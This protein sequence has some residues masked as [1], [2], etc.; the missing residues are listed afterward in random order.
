MI[1]RILKSFKVNGFW[2]TVGRVP[3]TFSRPICSALIGHRLS[4]RNRRSTMSL[5]GDADAVVSLTSYGSRIH[6]VHLTIESIARGSTRPRR[7]IL[8]LDDKEALLDPTSELRRLTRRGLELRYAPDYGPHKKYFPALEVSLEDGASRLI[9]ADDDVIYPRW[10]LDRLMSAAKEDPSSIVAYR[11][12]R[13]TLTHDGFAAWNEWPLCASSTPSLLNF[14]IGEAGVAYPRSVLQALRAR[15]TRFTELAPRVDDIWLHS[16]AIS[17]NVRTRQVSRKPLRP[18][19]VPGS[20]TTTLAQ[21][22]I[23]GGGNDEALRKN[24]DSSSLA[25]LKLEQIQELN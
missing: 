3:R 10:W 19:I 6:K 17:A 11:A 24:Y 21:S 16:T 9:T 23:E 13:V 7:L 15:G 25:Q 18:L 2:G 5:I 22:N 8:W 14:S 12:R 1:R 20:Q 4:I